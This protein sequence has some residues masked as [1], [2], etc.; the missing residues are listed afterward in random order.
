MTKPK[1][2]RLISLQYYSTTV[3]QDYSTTPL[4]VHHNDRA[5][6]PGALQYKAW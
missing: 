6:Q 3:L 4:S 2:H 1:R 5:P